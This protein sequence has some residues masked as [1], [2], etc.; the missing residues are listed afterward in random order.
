MPLKADVLT[1]G[2]YVVRTVHLWQ[3]RHVP[4][5]QP[6]LVS[7][8]GLV[9]KSRSRYTVCFLCSSTPSSLRGGKCTYCITVGDPCNNPCNNIDGKRGRFFLLLF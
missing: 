8:R 2:Q 3:I 7:D 4:I 1:D 6:V 5:R 9:P